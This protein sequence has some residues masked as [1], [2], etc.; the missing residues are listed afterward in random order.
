MWLLTGFGYVIGFTKHL[1]IITTGNYNAI[2]NSHSAIHYSTHLRLL[3]LLCSPVAWWRILTMSSAFVLTFL[4]VG[5]CLRT[6]DSQLKSTPL[7][8]IALITPRVRVTLRL[9]VCRQSVRLGPKPFETHDQRF[10]YF[11]LNPCCHS[12]YIA[13]SLTRGCDCNLQLLLGLSSAVQSFSGLSPAG[14]MTIF[15][16]LRFDTPPTWRARSPYFYPPGAGWPSYTPGHWV[17][18]SLPPTTRRDTV[19]VFEPASTRAY[20]TQLSR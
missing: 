12:P 19:K 5:D 16:R 6:V 15:Y 18:F 11:Q 1:Q 7:H 13:S 8:W 10:F 9:A 3:S 17:P 20:Y 4:P 2:A 14:L